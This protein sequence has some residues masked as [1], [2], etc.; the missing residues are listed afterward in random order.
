MNI[1]EDGELIINP[2]FQRLFRWSNEQQTRFMESLILGIPIPPI[3]VAADENSRWELVD[4]LQRVSTVLSFF[5]LLKTVPR[6]NNWTM[7]EGEIIDELEGFNSKNLPFKHTV[8]V[9]RAVCRVEI[10]KSDSERDMRFELF[11]RLNTGGTP[12]TPQEIRNCIYRGISNKFN[13]YLEELVNREEFVKLIR[14]TEPKTEQ[15]YLQELVLRFTS[16]VLNW[17][18]I[19]EGLSNYMTNFMKEAVENPDFDYEMYRGLFLRT[20]S[21]LSEYGDDIFLG[22]NNM[23][24]PSLF[25]GITI[26]IAN[27]VD[28]YE[29]NKETLKEKIKEIKKDDIFIS[30]MGSAASSKN[31]VKK[32]IKRAVEIFEPMR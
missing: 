27:N 26:G 8:N 9:K 13:E 4:G 16:L 18:D 7:C 30:Y 21:L 23:F 22:R 15:M 29:K 6:K 19:N 31:R 25:E 24:S 14:T 5:G 17:K 32:R 11:N 3:F 12:L 28:Y 2:E 1:Y 20:F 10:I